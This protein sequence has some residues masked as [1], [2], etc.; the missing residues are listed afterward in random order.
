MILTTKTA[1]REDDFDICLEF[2]SGSMFCNKNCW[3]CCL[4]C[5]VASRVLNQM[6]IHIH[7][8]SVFYRRNLM[9]SIAVFQWRKSTEFTHTKKSTKS[10]WLIERLVE[11]CSTHHWWCVPV[12]VIFPYQFNYCTYDSLSRSLL[13]LSVSACEVYYYTIDWPYAATVKTVT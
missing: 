11:I 3:I 4:V 9:E 5:W 10:V 2:N 6:K 1:T 13:S 12:R 8:L 7:I